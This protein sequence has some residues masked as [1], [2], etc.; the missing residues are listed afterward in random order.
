[1]RGG[2]SEGQHAHCE[3][4]CDR[5]SLTPGGIATTSASAPASPRRVLE[6]DRTARGLV[7][8]QALGDSGLTHG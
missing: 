3:K 4:N 1:M 2:D 8:V 7:A 5:L 6:P